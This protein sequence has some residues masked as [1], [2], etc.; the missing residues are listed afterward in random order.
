MDRAILA[1]LGETNVQ[2]TI[3]FYLERFPYPPYRDDV[4]VFVIQIQFPFII[5]LSFIVTAPSISKDIVLEKERKLK[6][7]H[8]SLHFSGLPTGINAWI[9]KN[10][11]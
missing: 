8:A 6:V 9:T 7:C 10:S 4:F 11:R 1:V 2:E 5:L 3:D